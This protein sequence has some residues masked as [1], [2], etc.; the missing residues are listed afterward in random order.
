[1]P[2]KLRHGFSV[3]PKAKAVPSGKSGATKQS[4]APLNQP[5]IL[6]MKKGEFFPE[7]CYC[8]QSVLSGRDRQSDRR[9]DQRV[10][11]GIASTETIFCDRA[12]VMRGAGRFARD[13]KNP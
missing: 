7:L 10:R 11:T 9:V 8:S 4:K 3:Y 5:F 12:A 1:M 2:I 6:R 13:F